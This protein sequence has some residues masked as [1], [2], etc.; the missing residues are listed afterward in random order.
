[1]KTSVRIDHPWFEIQSHEKSRI[2]ARVLSYICECVC[3]RYLY[4]PLK[5]EYE[6]EIIYGAL[7]DKGGLLLRWSST[8]DKGRSYQNVLFLT[9]RGIIFWTQSSLIL[10]KASFSRSVLWFYS[11][12]GPAFRS[13]LRPPSS[14]LLSTLTPWGDLLPVFLFASSCFHQ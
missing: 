13:G 12:W 4:P 1:V 8:S 7:R 5:Q 14:S 2:E 6:E 11:S 9:E 3:G 10:T